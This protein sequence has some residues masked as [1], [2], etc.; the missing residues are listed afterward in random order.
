MNEKDW[1]RFSAL[2]EKIINNMGGSFQEK[3]AEVVRQI[4]DDGNLNEFLSWFNG[5]TE[6]D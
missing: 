4:G 1:E 2:L 3:K 6:G 5:S